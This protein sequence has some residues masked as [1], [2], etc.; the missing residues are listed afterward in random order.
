M[1]PV[2]P[3][4]A[5]GEECDEGEH[6]QGHAGADHDS[7]EAPDSQRCGSDPT[8]AHG[9]NPFH[10]ALEG[11]LVVG[12][13]LEARGAAAGFA[14]V[15]PLRSSTL[16]T[17]RPRSEGTQPPLVPIATTSFGRISGDHGGLSGRRGSEQ[18]GCVD[19]LVASEVA[20][21]PGVVVD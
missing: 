11:P 12:E 15:A 7:Q 17:S 20:D 13:L 14:S 9:S 19:A 3:L 10:A 2:R 4:H 21:D 5:V 6:G 18:P 1:T 16:P 8:A